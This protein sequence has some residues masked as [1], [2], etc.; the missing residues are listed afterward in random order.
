MQFFNRRFPAKITQSA[1]AAAFIFVAATAF[2]AS[3]AASDAALELTVDA[4]NLVEQHQLASPLTMELQSAALERFITY[5][6]A[7]KSRDF[8][9]AYQMLRLSY[10]AANPRLEWEMD[11]RRRDGLWVDGK[12]RLLRQSWYH[13]PASQPEGLYAALDFR[14][15]RADGSM[16]C[17]YVVLHQAVENGPFTIVRT[18]TSFVPEHLLTEGVPQQDVLRQLPCFLGKGIAT[19]L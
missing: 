9:T 7:L 16:D 3:A 8:G 18:D 10:Q 11:Q 13:N 5:A 12:M 17:G 1:V 15:D 19:A 4:S 14:G 6:Q 2:S